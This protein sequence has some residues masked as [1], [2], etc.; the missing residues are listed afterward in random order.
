MFYIT[1]F[2]FFTILD[3][4]SYSFASS[5]QAL[6][7]DIG[8]TGIVAGVLREKVHGTESTWCCLLASGALKGIKKKLLRPLKPCPPSHPLCGAALFMVAVKSREFLLCIF[9]F[10]AQQRH[11]KGPKT[12]MNS[13]Y[14]Y[15]SIPM[16]SNRIMELITV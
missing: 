1:F 7:S 11:I 3:S 6:G 9:T 16:H 4:P 12:L 5:L 10:P 14:V 2:F 13:L 8:V 15:V